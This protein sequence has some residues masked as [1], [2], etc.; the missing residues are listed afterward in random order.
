MCV[1]GCARARACVCVCVCVCDSVTDPLFCG[2]VSR[3]LSNESSRARAADA[4]VDS[5]SPTLALSTL[6]QGTLGARDGASKG[7]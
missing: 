2:G 5:A 4:A 6:A 3:N 7:A 1:G